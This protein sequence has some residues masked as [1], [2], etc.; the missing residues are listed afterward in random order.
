MVHWGTAIAHDWNG[1]SG[2]GSWWKLTAKFLN[3]FIGIF[4]S[5]WY[6][7]HV[8]TRNSE[9]D[10]SYIPFWK[11]MRGIR[12]WVIYLVVRGQGPVSE[13]CMSS[14][15]QGMM[16]QF[17][18][19]WKS[20]RRVWIISPEMLL[21]PMFWF[22][23]QARAAPSLTAEQMDMGVVRAYSLSTLLQWIF[24]PSLLQWTHIFMG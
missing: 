9:V 18:R 11:R 5:V 23:S 7:F 19:K 13:R 16:C 14:E 15:W 21:L 22:L 4:G 20:V 2:R 6:V 12:T 17:F 8:F 1:F 24:E 10:F 3:F